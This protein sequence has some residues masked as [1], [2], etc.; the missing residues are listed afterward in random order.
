MG[1][2]QKEIQ[3]YGPEQSGFDMIEAKEPKC[4]SKIE[5]KKV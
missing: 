3:T 5:K 1:G 2:V 4:E